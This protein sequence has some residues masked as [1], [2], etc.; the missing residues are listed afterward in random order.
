MYLGT[1]LKYKLGKVLTHTKYI[2]NYLN[3]AH[4]WTPLIVKKLLE[5][6]NENVLIQFTGYQNVIDNWLG[7]YSSQKIRCLWTGPILLTLSWLWT[8]QLFLPEGSRLWTGLTL[9]TRV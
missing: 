6:A 1:Q 9:F 5:T 8:A 4:P 3:T 2:R 7:H